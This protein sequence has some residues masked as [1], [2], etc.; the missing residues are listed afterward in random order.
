MTNNVYYYLKVTTEET[1][2]DPEISKI[3]LP[4]GTILRLSASGLAL[5]RDGTILVIMVTS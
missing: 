5:M 3:V 4:M 1:Q 2:V